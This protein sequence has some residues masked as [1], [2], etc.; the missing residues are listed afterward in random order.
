MPLLPPGGPPP[1]LG[2]FKTAKM[3]YVDDT[4]YNYPV[5]PRP[6]HGS[7]A[8]LAEAALQ[9]DKYDHAD[10]LFRHARAMIEQRYAL[11]AD[12]LTIDCSGRCDR[13]RRRSSCRPQPPDSPAPCTLSAPIPPDEFKAGFD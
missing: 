8:A 4:K 3:R 6:S 5:P 7:Y 2:T 12:E 10:F 13:A 1:H 11:E 9:A